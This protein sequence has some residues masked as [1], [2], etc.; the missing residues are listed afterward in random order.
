MDFLSQQPVHQSSQIITY[1]LNT[2]RKKV[3][4]I[5]VGDT[6][7]S[8]QTGQMPRLICVFAWCTGHF[9]IVFHALAVILCRSVR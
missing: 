7:D 9:Q 4:M 3:V 1:A 8:E 6:E 5:S 2:I